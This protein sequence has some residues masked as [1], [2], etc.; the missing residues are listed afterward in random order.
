MIHFVVIDGVVF[1][2]G[3]PLLHQV[4]LHWPM[5]WFTKTCRPI[6]VPW[7]TPWCIKLLKRVLLVTISGW[8][9]HTHK[10]FAP[11]HTWKLS[12]SDFLSQILALR[13]VSTQFFSNSS[14]SF[15]SYVW[16]FSV[17]RVLSP[18]SLSNAILNQSVPLAN[19]GHAIAV[20]PGVSVQQM[21]SVISGKQKL[22]VAQ[23]WTDPNQSFKKFKQPQAM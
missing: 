23:V 6:V 17:A 11:Y 8:R 2:V 14:I 18:T 10:F 12:T 13:Q 4:H 20:D 15:A 5:Q 16:R 7:V 21:A 1:F 3:L 22:I 9:A 19:A